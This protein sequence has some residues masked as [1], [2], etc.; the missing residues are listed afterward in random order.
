MRDLSPCTVRAHTAIFH[1]LLLGL[2]LLPLAEAAVG[3]AEE[4]IVFLDTVGIFGADVL[5]KHLRQRIEVVDMW[6]QE[7]RLND[8]EDP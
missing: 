6:T 1:F 4:E 2:H 8:G 5:K 3:E 7:A